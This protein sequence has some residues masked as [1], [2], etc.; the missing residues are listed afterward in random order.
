MIASHEIQKKQGLSK[1]SHTETDGDLTISNQDESIQHSVV[2]VEN[3]LSA[4]RKEI[5]K[6][7]SQFGEVD[8]VWVKSNSSENIKDTSSGAYCVLYKNKE[9]A[10]LSS[11]LN[12]QDFKGNIL[13]VSIVNKPETELKSS[14]FINN[15]PYN[16]TEEE[17]RSKFKDFGQIREIKIPRGKDAQKGKGFAHVVYSNKKEAKKALSMNNYMLS[18]RRLNVTRIKDKETLQKEKKSLQTKEPAHQSSNPFLNPKKLTKQSDY[19]DQSFDSAE[20][21]LPQKRERKIEKK[22]NKKN[23]KDMT[24]FQ[25]KR[26]QR[27][28]WNKKR[29]K[30]KNKVK[31]N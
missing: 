9:E 11:S 15:L 17:L 30:T 6:L 31:N 7:F 26:E 4:T 19:T 5:K 13:S 16:I 3:A 27:G 22:Q 20:I 24:K 12:G 14:I 1:L 18:G 10:S 23:G 25:L 29:I 28:D 8:K 2:L 21:K